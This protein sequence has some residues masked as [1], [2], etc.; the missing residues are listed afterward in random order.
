[1]HIRC[2]AARRH[3]NTRWPCAGGCGMKRQRST[4]I[5]R[6]IMA[7][8]LVGWLVRIIQSVALSVWNEPVFNGV[9]VVVVCGRPLGSVWLVAAGQRRGNSKV[10][11]VRAIQQH[12][13]LLTIASI[14]SPRGDKFVKNYALLL[15]WKIDPLIWSQIILGR[16]L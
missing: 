2:C 9:I 11:R 3:N 16:R 14:K 8:W 5:V 15:R 13:S 7:Y 12:S 10:H 1:M 4:A 6:I